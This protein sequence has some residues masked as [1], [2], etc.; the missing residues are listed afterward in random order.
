M[1]GILPVMSETV[2]RKAVTAGLALNCTIANLSKFDR[3][4]YFYP[5]LPKGYQISQFDSP[6]CHG[7]SLE[8]QLPNGETKRFGVTRVHMEEDTG[9]LYSSGQPA[10]P[11]QCMSHL[12]MQ[13][14]NASLP[15]CKHLRAPLQPL[16]RD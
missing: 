7:G 12:Q 15:S 1:Q 2:L 10:M 3:K 8:A 9:K 16:A 11:L 14:P 5:D 13:P 6:L 4:Q